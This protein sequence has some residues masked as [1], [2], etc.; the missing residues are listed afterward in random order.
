MWPRDSRGTPRWKQPCDSTSRFTKRI[1][2]GP[3]ESVTHL[4]WVPTRLTQD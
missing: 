2:S 1:W 4:T 3:G